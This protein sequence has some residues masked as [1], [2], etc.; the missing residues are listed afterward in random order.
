M[1]ELSRRDEA[2]V[3][4]LTLDRPAARNA[5]SLSLIA[6]LRVALTDIGGDDRVRVVVIAG[7]GPA[8]CAGHDLRE[9][10]GLA[11]RPQ[12]EAL[13]AACSALMQQIVLLPKPVI[14]RVHG[15]ATAAGVP[16]GGELRSCD[17]GGNGAVCDAG[18]CHR[19]VL[20][21]ADGGADPGGRTQGGDGDAADRRPHLRGAGA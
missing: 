10:R 21:D 14:A 19:V 1:E 17:C 4:Y 18:G 3:A 7:A 20:L 12:I 9:I 2:G 5:L 13:F 6:E 16:A 8:F 15:V 11:A